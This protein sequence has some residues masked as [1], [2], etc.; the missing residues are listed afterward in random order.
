[1]SS[2]IICLEPEHFEVAKEVSDQYL[3]LG[4]TCQ[5]KN[6]LNALAL[7]CFEQWLRER[8]LNIK[9]HR[10]D[11]RIEISDSTHVVDVVCYLS[12]G[13]F[14]FCLIPVDN[15]I[16]G[17]VTLPEEVVNSPKLAAHFYVVIEVLEEEK[18]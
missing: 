1:M 12:L 17:F 2:K 3:D 10:H 11:C 14:K 15:L 13:E 9:I 7:F 18:N 8:V 6:Y 4:E 16:D 5:W